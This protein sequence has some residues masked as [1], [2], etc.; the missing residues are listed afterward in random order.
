MNL[1]ISTYQL[2]VFYFVAKEKSF[3]IAA[4]KLFLTQPTVTNHIKSLE[5]HAGA[6]LI[7]TSNKK[8]RLTPTGEGLFRY[9]EQIYRQAVAAET[10]IKHTKESSLSIGVCP[11]CISIIGEALN[12][13]AREFTDSMKLKVR[14]EDPYYML[15]ELLDSKNDV[16]ILP[17]FDYGSKEL[18][19]IR[20]ADAVRIVFYASP[21][22][23]I[24]KKE[25]IE[26]RN[27]ID[28]PIFIGPDNYPLHKILTQKLISE[29]VLVPINAEISANNSEISKIVVQNGR[30]I[31]IALKRDIE[32]EIKQEKLKV[33]SMPS[34]FLID[35]DAIIRFDS[36]ISNTLQN[37]ISSAKSSFVNE[38]S[39]GSIS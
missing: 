26:W 15:Q 5:R 29:R 8:V 2:I 17:S 3:T 18:R 14:S 24:F 35:V 16:V 32:N 25:Q 9:A 7:E 38:S 6:K 23:E 39:Y 31:G 21:S 27:L 36:F 33:I 34:D 20:I 11:F 13:M 12:N 19:H 10:F 22:N 28:Y 37:F 1:N 4:E 30:A